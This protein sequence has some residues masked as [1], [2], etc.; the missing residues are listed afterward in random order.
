MTHLEEQIRSQPAALEKMITS[1][2]VRQRVHAAAAGLHRARR[3][4]V[5]GTGTSYHAAELG[6]MMIREAGRSAQAYSSQQ[7][8]HNAPNVASQDALIVITHT[9]ETAYALAVRSLGFQ[10]GLD[11]VT[12]T[13]SGGPFPDAVETVAKETSETYTVSYTAALVALAM[14]A[15]ELGADSASD[16]AIGRVPAAVA[17]ALAS[18]GI[19]A[20]PTPERLLAIAGVGPAAWSAAEGALKVREAS[21]FLAEGYDAEYLLHGSAVPLTGS[22]RLLLLAPP[23]SDGFVQALGGAATEAGVPVS[24]IEETADLPPLLAQ[25]P[26]AARLQLLALR[27]SIERGQD[28]DK[29]IVGPWDDPG[30]WSLGSPTA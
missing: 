27:I 28:P 14:L 4:W 13:R 8:V 22:D 18:P 23:D 5:V 16:E 20:V 29:V 7:F 15:R 26:L 9:A 19:A 2:T 17:E 6:A 1:G 10:A 25:I 3:I 30:L 24:T 12:I 11:I 21:R